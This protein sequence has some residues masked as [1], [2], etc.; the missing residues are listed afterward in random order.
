[1]NH[2]GAD[3]AALEI[4]LVEDIEADIKI[5]LRAFGRTNFNNNIH[6]VHNGKEALDYLRREGDFADQTKYPMPSLIL[7]DIQ[8]PKL[9]GFQVLDQMKSDPKT[10]MIPVVMLT[11]SKNNED[12]VNSYARG[13]ASFIQKPLN[14]KDFLKV[15]DGFNIYWHQIN[16]LPNYEGNQ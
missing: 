9:T 15:V 12:V 14:Y 10:R 6:V 7:L 1:M 11:S 13:A 3:E 2:F 5:A 8:L 4:L 16:S